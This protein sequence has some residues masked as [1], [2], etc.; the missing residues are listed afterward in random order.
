MDLFTDREKARASNQAKQ[1]NVSLF[2][3]FFGLNDDFLPELNMH[4]VYIATYYLH[5]KYAFGC[6]YSI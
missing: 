4:T 6:R 2:S 3:S 1:S 5:L